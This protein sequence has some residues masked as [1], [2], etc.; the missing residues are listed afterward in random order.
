MEIPAPTALTDAEGAW[1]DFSYINHY[2][3]NDGVVLCAF[4]DPRDD[5]AA[6]V[7]RDL[8]PGR[9]VTPVDA[10]TIFA[11]GGGIHCITQQQPRI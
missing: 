3:C 9:T 10:R 8:F 1:A 7:F 2:L 6:A 5:E 11:G 4:D